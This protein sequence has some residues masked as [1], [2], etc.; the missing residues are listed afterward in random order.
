MVEIAG[1]GSGAGIGVNHREIQLVF[2]GIEVDEQIVDLVQNFGNAGVGAVDF[3][4]ANDGRQLG[5][6]SL[7]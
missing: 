4:D 5:L 7:F 3:I 6:E 2:G 1:G